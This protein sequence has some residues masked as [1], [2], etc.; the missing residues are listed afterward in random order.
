MIPWVPSPD[1]KKKWTV[2]YKTNS[3]FRDKDII[4]WNGVIHQHD[5]LILK[6]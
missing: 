5:I 4:I 2:E 6:F 1:K 3:I